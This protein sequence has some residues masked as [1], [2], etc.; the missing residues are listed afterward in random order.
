MTREV[1]EEDKGE[2]DVE[3]REQRDKRTTGAT[4]LLETRT[5][6]M[7]RTWAVMGTR[8]NTEGM[9]WDKVENDGDDEYNSATTLSQRTRS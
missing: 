6:M 7:S 5:M 3:T 2:D 9:N 1:Q 4:G 8:S